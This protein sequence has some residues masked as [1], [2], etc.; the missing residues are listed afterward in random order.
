MTI[1][2]QHSKKLYFDVC[3]L[4]RPFDDQNVMKI[5]I[6]TDAFYLILEA[7]QNKKYKMI[8]SPVHFEEINAIK[9]PHERYELVALLTKYGTDLPC[10]LGK[11]RARA[12]YLYSKRFGVADASH[13]AFAEA[14][15]DFFISCDEKLLKKCLKTRINIEAMNPVKFAV[16]EDLK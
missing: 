8:A 2:N 4:C 9:D 15:A 11:I 13:I 5:R 12:E 1:K 16:M 10:D 7:L 3:T 6:E 14:T